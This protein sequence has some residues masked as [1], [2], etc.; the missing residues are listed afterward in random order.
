MAQRELTNACNC[1]SCS[2]RTYHTRSVSRSCANAT[3]PGADVIE[4]PRPQVPT[5]ESE[6]QDP[7][8]NI[9]EDDYHL[10]SN[11][12][13]SITLFWSLIIRDEALP[14]SQDQD[15][16]RQ[17]RP[18]SPPDTVTNDTTSR[19][20]C[21]GSPEDGPRC[22]EVNEPPLDAAVS[23][24]E[25]LEA[26]DCTPGPNDGTYQTT[27]NLETLLLGEELKR[28]RVWK[29]T[30]SNDELNRLPFIEHEVAQGVLRCLT[31]VANTLIKGYSEWQASSE[32]EDLGAE[33]DTLHHLVKQVEATM[34]EAN[35]D[36][37]AMTDI[38]EFSTHGSAC[39]AEV[40]TPLKALKFD[41]DRLQMLSHTLRLG[42]SNGIIFTGHG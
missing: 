2:R 32:S 40:E 17:E 36:D 15:E 1:E 6:I 20:E 28:L 22:G 9:H 37:E 27:F 26:R 38:V 23:E 16:E 34:S 25:E 30:F 42:L 18:P 41:I 35:L 21:S 31:G 39:T 29:A 19:G 11:L 13:D 10:I 12:F 4:A 7:I 8:L 14:L 24:E 3:Q 33:K 5:P